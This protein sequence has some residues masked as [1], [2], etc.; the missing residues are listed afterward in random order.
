MLRKSRMQWYSNSLDSFMYISRTN[1][2]N[3]CF[4]TWNSYTLWIY[5]IIL[6]HG[7]GKA[8][9][10]PVVCKLDEFD[11]N[12]VVTL[13]LVCV[14]IGF[15]GGYSTIYILTN[16]FELGV[17][18]VRLHLILIRYSNVSRKIISRA[19]QSS[20]WFKRN[21]LFLFDFAQKRCKFGYF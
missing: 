9:V 17:G 13:S 8:L 1:V 20:T 6:F 12:D 7:I 3:P 5:Y 16:M 15:F 4:L 2:I 18:T 10:D 19:S 11:S 21:E 14:S